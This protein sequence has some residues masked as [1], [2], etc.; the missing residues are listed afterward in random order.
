M[1]TT[2]DN[3]QKISF[4]PIN[5]YILHESIKTGYVLSAFWFFLSLISLFIAIIIFEY[6]LF[7]AGLI[8]LFL[9]IILLYFEL[10]DKI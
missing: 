2:L 5:E 10:Y 8:F 9:S 3:I 1:D 7:I 6:P 4:F